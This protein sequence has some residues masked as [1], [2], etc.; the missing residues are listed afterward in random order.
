MSQGGSSLA[1]YPDYRRVEP[2]ADGLWRVPDARLARRHRMNIGTIV[3]DA[4]ITVQYQGGAR[5]GSVEESFIARMKIGDCFMFGGRLLELIRVH[6]MTA[7]VRRATPSRA[8]VPRW[9][10]S[11]FPLSVTLA[12]RP[13]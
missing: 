7:W 5:I 9:G 10:G 8:A 1:A 2:D 3:S 6:E 11:R 4:S 12:E 13:N